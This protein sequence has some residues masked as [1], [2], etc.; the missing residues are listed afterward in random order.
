MTAR[1]YTVRPIH[2]YRLSIDSE[3]AKS[4]TLVLNMWIFPNDDGFSF[5][6]RLKPSPFTPLSTL[7]LGK[8]YAEIMPP[9]L[10]GD[11]SQHPTHHLQSFRL[12]A[13][14]NLMHQTNRAVS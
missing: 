8:I 13:P 10:P 9:V 5:H 4:K 3:T 2:L 12:R 7:L 6:H 14:T 11:D 1:S